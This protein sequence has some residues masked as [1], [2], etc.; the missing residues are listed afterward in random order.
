M[1]KTLTVLIVIILFSSTLSAQI[2]LNKLDTYETGIF[3]EGAAEIGAYDVGSDR[4]FFTN[5][6]ENTVVVLDMSDPHNIEFVTK[7]DMD[8]WGGGVN[9]VAAYDGLFAVAVEADDKQEDGYVV[10]FDAGGVALNAV[11][12]GALPDMVTFT[13]DGK[14]LLAANEGEPDDDY[15]IDPEGSVSIIPISE[16]N[17]YSLSDA[18]VT[19]VTFEGITLPDDP[20]IR[21]FGPN[22]T[23]AQDLEPEYIA[24]S[25]DSKTAFVSCQENNAVIKIDIETG[26]VISI[27][28]LGFKNHMAFK[29]KLDA[30]NR[31]DMINLANWPVMGIYMPDAITTFHM[32]GE[33][34]ILS[35]NEGDSRDYD[36]YSEEE[37]VEDLILDPEAFP[38]AQELQAEEN[39][40]RLHITTSMGD[41]DNDGDFD[42]L[43]SYGARSFSIWSAND[44][45]LV[46]DS[47]DEFERI[48]AE[49]YPEHF[50]S[51]N[52]DND[53]FDSRSDDKG[54]EPEAVT[55]GEIDN[56]YYAFIGLERMG[57][58]M[59]YEITDP[60]R[61]HFVG[62][63]LDRDF[64]GDAEEGTAGDLAP[65]NIV[66]IPADDSPTERDLLV[67][68]SEVS[69]TVTTYEITEDIQLTHNII[70]GGVSE[71][72]ANF[73]VRLNASADVEVELEGYDNEGQLILARTNRYYASPQNDYTVVLHAENLLPN[74]QYAYRVV[75]NEGQP[76]KTIIDDVPRSFKTFPRKGEKANFTFAFGSCQ[77]SGSL[78]P[79]DTPPGN[80][81]HE[82]L[83][84]AP[85]LFLQL[86][87]WGYPDTTDVTPID[88]N[89]YSADK[90]K[91]I[92][93]YL[94]RYQKNYPMEKIFRN[95]PIDYVWDDHDYM[96]DNASALTSSF[97]IPVRPN[98]FGDDF[99]AME[100]PNPE[101]ARENSIETYKEYFP[102]YPLENESRGIYHKF[103]YGNVDFFALDLRAQRDGSMNAV[104]FQE[105]LGRWTF[106]PPEGHS[107]LG[108]NDA[109]GT[110]QSQLDWF[111]QELQNSDADWKFIVSS[112]PFN[113]GQ[114][115]AIE[116]GVQ[117]QDQVVAVPGIP[118]GSTAIF[119]TM[120][121]ADKWAGYPE[122]V[123]AV[124]GFIEQN[125]IENVVV[126]SGDSHN[127]AIDDGENAGL[128]E[129]MAGGLEITNSKIAATFE[130]F[131]VS[132]WNQGG[133]GLSTPE[134]NNAFGKVTV[135]EADSVQL[136]LID[137]FG[138]KFAGYTLV[139]GGV[140]STGEYDAVVNEYELRQN[141][142]N[143]FNPATTIAYSIPEAGQV[144]LKVFNMLGQEV[145]TL[146]NQEVTAGSHQVKFDASNLASGIYF[147]QIK[148]GNFVQTKKL[149]LLK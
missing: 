51:N 93:S 130:Q 53:S 50:N 140:T 15:E 129:I 95:M 56:R 128:P 99:V 32:F 148:A 57:G 17:I 116:L 20:S 4:F 138:T 61:V 10:L 55:V 28:G 67:V 85:D 26:T 39:L 88:N 87:D 49:R 78:L 59:I 22:A 65:E 147:Y 30:S 43:Y 42:E 40:G 70:V 82:V 37:R 76:N 60:D 104:V 131:G 2:K 146:V 98:P 47:G 75:L 120:E 118:E 16:D 132:I 126:L 8:V 141:Y 143:P 63:Q 144:T 52:D 124:L 123:E 64:T 81:F 62:Y 9:S 11:K 80:V 121:F 44:L 71:D 110:G 33:D 38:N 29:N 112:V 3:D 145:T 73:W 72:K 6:E 27:H 5:A 23:V 12:A 54:P 115:Q 19:H 92:D 1:K 127:A 83:R 100:I 103:S 94:H 134:F 41:T 125:N 58:I 68:T 135:F 89:F 91:V 77:Q 109:P 25:S 114:R 69:G 117:L 21:I 48:I 149:M 24:V 36:G 34:F 45:S 18:D 107:I 13:P 102:G 84:H 139:N 133:Q 96:N 113:V 108:R 86:G 7:I 35:A 119:A 136:E 74:T 111:L 105:G 101:G 66:F 137:E 97:F 79:S 142:P 122:D 14:Y 106:S 90:Q 31:D 46:Y